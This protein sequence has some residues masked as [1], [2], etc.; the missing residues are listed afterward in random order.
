MSA[1]ANQRHSLMSALF[2]RCFWLP[3]AADNIPMLGL[4]EMTLV[5]LHEACLMASA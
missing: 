4:P 5:T 3:L 1:Q 2:S